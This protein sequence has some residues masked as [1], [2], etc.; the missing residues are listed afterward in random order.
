VI[1][2][3]ALAKDVHTNEIRS[4]RGAERGERMTA[5]TTPHAGLDGP[6]RR[7]DVTPKPQRAPAPQRPE[8][9]PE[10]KPIR[11]PERK[12]ANEPAPA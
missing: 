5:T 1:A 6:S 8:R 11:A 3:E 2:G 10:R 7:I 12:P 4:P 9:A